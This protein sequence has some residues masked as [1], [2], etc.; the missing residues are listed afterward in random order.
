ML[1]GSVTS[2]WMGWGAV[3]VKGLVT[4]GREA[5]GSCSS[6]ISE[7]VLQEKAQPATIMTRQIRSGLTKIRFM[8]GGVKYSA[9]GGVEN[10]ARRV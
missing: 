9:Q 6:L 8:R 5:V 10:E 7:F 2:H 1:S 4:G 3:R